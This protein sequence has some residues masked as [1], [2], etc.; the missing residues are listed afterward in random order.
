MSQTPYRSKAKYFN[1]SSEAAQHI[2]GHLIYAHGA[3]QWSNCGLF[4]M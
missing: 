3:V 2:L 1:Q 4:N